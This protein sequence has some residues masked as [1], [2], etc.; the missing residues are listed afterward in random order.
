VKVTVTTGPTVAVGLPG[1]VMTVDQD[2]G[3]PELGTVTVRTTVAVLS[4][5]SG[6]VTVNTEPGKFAGWAGTVTVTPDVGTP[7]MLTVTV[8][9]DPG[10]PGVAGIV[11]VTT[12]T[13]GPPLSGG[14]VTV[15]PGATGVLEPR[16]T[17]TVTTG[18]VT[19]LFGG[20]GSAVRVT[21]AAAAVPEG[22]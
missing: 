13:A 11:S 14:A 2:P 18:T 6:M 19:V 1:A 20:V 17:V 16:G 15:A 8:A 4:G 9:P 10:M 7:G 12:G 22:P 21:A 3:L 5:P